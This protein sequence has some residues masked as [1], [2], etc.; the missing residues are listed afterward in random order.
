MREGGC[1]VGDGS[2]SVNRGDT[3]DCFVTDQHSRRGG[4]WLKER[5]VATEPCKGPN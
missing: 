3:E 1:V 4:C 2:G 5:Q